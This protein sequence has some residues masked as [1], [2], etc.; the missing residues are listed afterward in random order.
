MTYFQDWSGFP[1]IPLRRVASVK[2]SNVDK[3]IEEG[4]QLVQLCNYVDV[5]YNETITNQIPFSGGSALPGE[6]DRFSLRN[7]D[8]VI[9]KD[10]ESPDDIAVPALVDESAAGVVCGYHLAI[11]RAVPHRMR[12]DFLFWSLKARPVKES[13]SIRAQG[14]TRFGLTLNGIGNVLLPMPDLA[15]QKAIADFLDRETVRIDQLI[16]KKER[17]LWL[18]DEKKIALGAMAGNGAL[19]DQDRDGALGWFGELPSKWPVRRGKFLFRERQGRSLSGSEEL[20]T[21]SHLTGITKRSEKEVNMFMAESL[22]GYK[23]ALRGDVVINTMWAWMGALGVSPL[24]G[25]VSPSYGVFTPIGMNFKP[26]YLDLI[27]RSVPF[28]AEVNRRSKG[29]YSSRLRLYPEAFLDIP[30][31]V[32]PIQE[33]HRVLQALETATAREEALT[34]LTH[35]SIARLRELRTTLITAAVTGQINVTTWGKQGETDRR[36]EAIEHDLEAE[37][38]EAAV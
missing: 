29:I 10:S 35:Q 5:Y 17:F 1:L 14:I 32:P 30:F 2:S 34:S 3:L 19:L 26:A 12:G 4:E 8:V 22:E 36:L 16:E 38:E 21:V 13:F 7:D 37:R 11:L 23:L 28:I 24:D 25:L 15:T 6:I 31:P 20:L 9:T 27:L 33:Q 18:V